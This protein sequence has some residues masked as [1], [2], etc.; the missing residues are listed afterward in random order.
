MLSHGAKQ[1][2][3]DGRITH[4]RD[5]KRNVDVHGKRGNLF[6]SLNTGRL[7]Q[8]IVGF[9]R[10]GFRQIPVGF[11]KVSSLTEIQERSDFEIEGSL[12]ST[13][14]CD[15][16]QIDQLRFLQRMGIGI[17][18]ENF[19][20]RSA[21]NF[22]E[23]FLPANLL[24]LRVLFGR[25]ARLGEDTQEFQGLDKSPVAG[26]LKPSPSKPPSRNP[27]RVP[28]C[29][30]R[31]KD[32]RSLAGR[33]DIREVGHVLDIAGASRSRNLPATIWAWAPRRRHPTTELASGDPRPRARSRGVHARR[34]ILSP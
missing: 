10:I 5:L 23:I 13:R 20:I 4:C 32:P 6:F 33:L 26:R 18:S 1:G 14:V 27:R 22:R 9:D 25:L 31:L 24:D 21:D 12:G 11:R 16:E 15:T 8:M 29:A 34:A 19:P 17:V 3:I 7:I 2:I 30:D 28:P